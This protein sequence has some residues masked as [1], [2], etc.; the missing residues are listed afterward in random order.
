MFVYLNF[1]KIAISWISF[2][3]VIYFI[4]DLAAD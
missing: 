2:R 3:F 4:K 1:L